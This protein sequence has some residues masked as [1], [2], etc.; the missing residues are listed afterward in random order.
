LD[1]QSFHI[2]ARDED[3][4]L[5]LKNKINEVSEYKSKLEYMKLYWTGVEIED[6]STIGEL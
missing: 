3:T 2:K 6:E 1:N 4:V 5:D